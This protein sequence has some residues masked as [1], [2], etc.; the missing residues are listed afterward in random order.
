VG[1]NKAL[2]A[3]EGFYKGSGHSLPCSCVEVRTKAFTFA[4]ARAVRSMA[5]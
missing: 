5:L 2:N 1:G 3:R 4:D